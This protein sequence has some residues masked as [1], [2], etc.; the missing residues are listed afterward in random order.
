MFFCALFSDT[1]H[2]KFDHML[3]KNELQ[4]LVDEIN[5]LTGFSAEKISQYIAF[6]KKGENLLHSIKSVNQNPLLEVW[7]DMAMTEINRELNERLKNRLLDLPHEMQQSEFLYS[8]SATSMVLT[9]I[10]MHL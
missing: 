7:I 8:R 1:F 5:S 2:S 3:Y 6:L 4:Q 10:F 9:N